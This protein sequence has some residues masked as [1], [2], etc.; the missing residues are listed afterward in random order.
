VVTV[1][2]I[3][4]RDPQRAI[5]T[6]TLSMSAG[7]TRRVALGT[8]TTPDALTYRVVAT[9]SDG[10][11]SHLAQSGR[12]RVSRETTTDTFASIANDI[13][14]PRCLSCHGF[15]RIPNLPIDLSIYRGTRA[16]PGVY[17]VRHRIYQRAVVA[18]NMPSGSARID[19]AD[20]SPPERER[21]AR[22]LLAGAP[23]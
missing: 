7:T 4:D 10:G 20:V 18:Q 15:P 19:G 1:S 5:E 21:L 13:L 14:A 17:D 3:D 2:L 11:A 16:A 22:W 8:V 6:Q 9:A 23:E 12:F